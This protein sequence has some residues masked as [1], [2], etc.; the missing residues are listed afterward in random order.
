MTTFPH[1]HR[2][3]MDLYMDKIEPMCRAGPLGCR[4]TNNDKL[5]EDL[6]RELRREEEDGTTVIPRAFDK[7]ANA[8]VENGISARRR[9]QT[10][11]MLP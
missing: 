3:L 10:L 4:I 1:P 2:A 6:I 11:R 8:A 9:I 7:A 5:A